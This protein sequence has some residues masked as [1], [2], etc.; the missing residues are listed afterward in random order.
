MFRREREVPKKKRYVQMAIRRKIR[1][2]TAPEVE[3]V[4]SDADS[5]ADD[6]GIGFVQK[7]NTDF[8]DNESY[9]DFVSDDELDVSEELLIE[10]QESFGAETAKKNEALLSSLAKMYSLAGDL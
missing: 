4:Q 5:N 8:F 6:Q 3:S 10:F 9:S 1:N 7:N 2:S